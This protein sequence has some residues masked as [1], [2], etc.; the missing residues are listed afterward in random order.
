VIRLLLDVQA[1]LTP[2][3]PTRWKSPAWMAAMGQTRP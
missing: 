2:D 3:K 1:G